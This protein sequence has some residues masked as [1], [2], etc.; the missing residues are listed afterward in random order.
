M[1]KEQ[2]FYPN[3]LITELKSE[4]SLGLNK[5]LT[6]PAWLKLQK[7]EGQILS[8]C[9]GRL[10][11]TAMIIGGGFLLRYGIESG[12]PIP[13]IGGVGVILLGGVA[14]HGSSS[15]IY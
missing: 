5:M 1:D 2:W 14:I 15:G 3:T 6:A 13:A 9:A 11:G 4:I 12:S 8:G 10:A 7:E